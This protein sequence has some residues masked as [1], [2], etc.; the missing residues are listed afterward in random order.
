[1]K[2]LVTGKNG[3]LSSTLRKYSENMENSQF[4]FIFLGRDQVNLLN[5]NQTNEVITA[6]NPDLIIHTAA[7]V[8][9]IK[10]NIENKVK[11]LLENL[12]IDSHVINSAFDS[13][14]QN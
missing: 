6:N 4:K 11:L 3:L 5:S 2:I 9:G 1:M 13:K 12:L 8:G 14:I 7:S 10:Y